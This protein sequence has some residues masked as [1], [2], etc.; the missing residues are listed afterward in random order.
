MTWDTGTARGSGT[1]TC[2][3]ERWTSA[4]TWA[5]LTWFA[6]VEQM[7]QVET[8]MTGLVDRFPAMNRT[9]LTRL[10]VVVACC[11]VGLLMGLPQVTQVLGVAGDEPR[12]V[13]PSFSG[14]PSPGAPETEA[15]AL[16]GDSHVNPLVGPSGGDLGGELDF[17]VLR[18]DDHRR[19]SAQTRTARST[20]KHVENA[21][22]C[23]QNTCDG[24]VSEG[25]GSGRERQ[26][27]SSSFPW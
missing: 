10:G 2:T 1:C 16:W 23:A 21:M 27:A 14:S 8:I 20:H 25:R 15:P 6:L 7:V 24:E 18:P 13:G 3:L 5:S 22:H 12:P 11:C 26:H 4:C 9:K 19:V 17:S